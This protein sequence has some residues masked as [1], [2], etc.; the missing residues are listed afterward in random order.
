MFVVSGDGVL[1]EMPLAVRLVQNNGWGEIG[2]GWGCRVW[3]NRNGLS[4][5][6][7]WED[8]GKNYCGYTAKYSSVEQYQTELR[9]VPER[10]AR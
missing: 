1:P 6:F 8:I 5:D 10:C 2:V 3:V 7:S 9:S 4:P